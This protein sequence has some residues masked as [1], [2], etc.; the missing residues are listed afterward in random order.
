MILALILL[1][2]LG[3]ASMYLVGLLT[4]SSTAEC[5]LISFFWPGVMLFVIV[6]IIKESAKQEEKWPI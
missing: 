1:Y 4:K 6:F 3:A 5:L 2:L